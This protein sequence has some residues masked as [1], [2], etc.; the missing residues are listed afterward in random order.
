[1]PKETVNYRIKRLVN[2][3]YIKFFYALVNASK[4]GYHY[5]KIFLQF[6]G[7]HS[8]K[9]TELISFIRTQPQTTNLRILEGNFNMAFI[10]MHK[11]PSEVRELLKKLNIRYGEFITGKSVHSVLVTHKLNQKVFFDGETVHEIYNLSESENYKVD[12]IDSKLINLLSSNARMKLVE[13]ARALNQDAQMV[14][15]RIK[16]LEDSGILANYSLAL[17]LEKFRRDFVEIDIKLKNYA[18]IRNIIEFF[19]NTR[20]CFFAYELLGEFDLSIELYTKDDS[21]LR[22]ILRKFKDMFADAYLVYDVSP[23]F[24]EYVINWSPLVEK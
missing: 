21:E 19:D 1:M 22:S 6:H 14:N 8:E 12:Y 13:I 2:N 17:N 24:K 16:K 7:L 20:T 5:Y 3:K 18:K 23:I 9:E 15:Y 11:H 4:F 10:S